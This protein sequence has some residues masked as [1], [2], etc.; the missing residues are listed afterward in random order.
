MDLMIRIHLKKSNLT[1]AHG[2]K[3]ILSTRHQSHL[4]RFQKFIRGNK[5]TVF[6]CYKCTC[7]LLYVGLHCLHYVWTIKGKLAICPHKPNG[8]QRVNIY[9]SSCG[10]VTISSN[11]IG[12]CSG[13][14]WFTFSY[15]FNDH[16]AY[17]LDLDQIIDWLP[18][19]NSLISKFLKSRMKRQLWWENNLGLFLLISF[20]NI[21][22]NL[23][24]YN[25]GPVS[26]GKQAPDK[27]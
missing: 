16:A 2:F 14:K 12:C 26:S 15:Q 7:V 23:W 11:L 10:S 8:H 9:R 20:T 27:S 18:S 5:W 1:T 3:I 17:K 4:V 6:A 25:G 13:R 24:P 19:S 21:F 22:I